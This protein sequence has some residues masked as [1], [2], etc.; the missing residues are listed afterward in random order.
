VQL[1]SANYS[2]EYRDESRRW[3]PCYGLFRL[4]RWKANDSLKRLRTG[5]E[6]PGYWKVP[7]AMEFI[8]LADN[9]E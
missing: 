4:T 3:K 6:I 5:D 8:E 1:D 9:V 2:I 7:G